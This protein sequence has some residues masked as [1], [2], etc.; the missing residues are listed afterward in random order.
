L[1]ETDKALQNSKKKFAAYLK[2]TDV[3][4]KFSAIPPQIK[5]LQEKA[6]ELDDIETLD[7]AQKE[8][9]GEMNDFIDSLFSTAA[10]SND[11]KIMQQFRSFPE[12]IIDEIDEDIRKQ[13]FEKDIAAWKKKKEQLK[14]FYADKK[15]LTNAEKEYKLVKNDLIKQSKKILQT[16][17]RIS[18]DM[19]NFVIAYVDES[20]P[21]ALDDAKLKKITA[22][23]EKYIKLSQEKTSR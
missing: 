18:P 2:T 23:M 1:H 15:A 17:E 7:S 6:D 20:K 13:Y 21:V 14:N 8:F 11:D 16:A 19:K 10:D 3:K 22:E 12:N 5:M 9:R 4:V